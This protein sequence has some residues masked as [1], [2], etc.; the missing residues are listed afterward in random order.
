MAVA[1]DDVAFADVFKLYKTVEK[2]GAGG[3]AREFAIVA[4][5]D[6]GFDLD[7]FSGWGVGAAGPV[8]AVL[9]T[10]MRAERIACS[11]VLFGRHHS[12][13][14]ALVDMGKCAVNVDDRC[15]AELQ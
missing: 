10:D 11:K 6:E 9:G 1:D 5:P 12:A 3:A 2:E 7:G 13:N 15:H 14:N 8:L 4:A